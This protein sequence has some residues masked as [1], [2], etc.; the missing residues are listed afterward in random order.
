MATPVLGGPNFIS[1]SV[2]ARYLGITSR[3]VLYHLES[4]RLVGVQ[5]MGEGGRWKVLRDSVVK[6]L[7]EMSEIQS[8]KSSVGV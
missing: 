2:A 4:G 8:N 1:V 5:V 7:P 6:R 3:M